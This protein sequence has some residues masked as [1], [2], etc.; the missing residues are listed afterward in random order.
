MFYMNLCGLLGY[1]SVFG[2]EI[3]FV[4]LSKDYDDLMNGVDMVIECGYVDEDCMFVYGCSG[5]GVLIVWVVGYM[6][7]FVVVLLNCLVINWFFFV[8]M[9]DGLNYWYCNFEKNFWEDLSEYLCCL[10]IMYVGNVMMLMMLMIGV[11][12]LCMLML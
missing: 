7:C 9:I 3:K 1:G 5:G 2:N 12:D 10:L 4:Y 11:N 8:G 6:D